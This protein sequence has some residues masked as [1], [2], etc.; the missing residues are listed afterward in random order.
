[1]P[2]PYRSNSITGSLLLSLPWH[3]SVFVA[4]LH[5]ASCALQYAASL[6]LPPKAVS[7]AVDNQAI[8]Y[9]PSRPSYSHQDPLLRDICKVTSTLLHSGKTV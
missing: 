5:A 2:R 3:M 6:S 1:M 4:E 7:L 8:T 9:T